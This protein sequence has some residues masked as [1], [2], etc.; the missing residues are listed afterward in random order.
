MI[1]TNS[2]RIARLA[3]RLVTYAPR[4][5]D[6][7]GLLWAAV[8]VVLVPAPDAILLIRRSDRAGDPWSGHMALPGGRRGSGDATLLDTAI[9]ESAEEVGLRLGP[10]DCIG[11][12]DDVAPR[13]PMLPPIA[14]RPYVF[15]IPARPLLVPNGEVASVHW[16]SIDS[17]LQPETYRAVEVDI[18]G[19]SHRV[20]AF[21][22]DDA[23]VWGMTERILTSLIPHLS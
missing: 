20:D 7:P 3:K 14:V 18:R 12:L 4:T 15:V 11:T 17:L 8:A 1:R 2:L 21:R 19:Q 16:A 10:Q 5:A 22:V 13:T 9:R 23:I 6:D